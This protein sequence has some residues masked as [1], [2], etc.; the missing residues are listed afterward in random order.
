[1][2]EIK[3]PL[4]PLQEGDIYRATGD[5]FV[6]TDRHTMNDIL[7]H[8]LHENGLDEMMIN[9]QL[10]DKYDKMTP[11]QRLT[12]FLKEFDDVDRDVQIVGDKRKL[13]KKDLEKVLAQVSGR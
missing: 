8:V 2:A 3:T 13:F 10:M 7:R 1:M 4:I 9:L 11:R 5:C 12:E 6:I